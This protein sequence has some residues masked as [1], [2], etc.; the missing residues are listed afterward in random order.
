M[1]RI[2]PMLCAAL[3]ACSAG[4][5]S[6]RQVSPAA[7]VPSP[8]RLLETP[9][10][11]KEGAVISLEDLTAGPGGARER[12]ELTPARDRSSSSSDRGPLP[13]GIAAT[14]GKA[15]YRLGIAP[16][17]DLSI[18]STSEAGDWIALVFGDT[19]VV[20]ARSLTREVDEPAPEALDALS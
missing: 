20:D 12:A 9:A 8:E 14:L 18:T 11:L 19:S 4:D 13:P 10:S 3:A 17:D 1:R 16:E 2:V 15:A 5:A 7:P 6:D